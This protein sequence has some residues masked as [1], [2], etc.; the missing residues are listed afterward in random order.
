MSDSLSAMSEVARAKVNLTLRVLGR[1][2]DGYHEL[3]SLVAFADVGDLLS[4]ELADGLSLELT[5]PFGASL[6]GE[7]DNLV[8]RAARALQAA[9]G[10]R[11]GARIR[12]DKRL[13]V[14]SGI[15]GGSA[16]AA[17]TLRGLARLW[18]I[19]D[20]LAPLALPLGADVPVCID[21]QTVLMEGIGERLTPVALPPLHMVLV[22]PG[23]AVPTGRVFQMLAAPLLSAVPAGQRAQNGIW[24]DQ[25]FMDWLSRQANDLEA[26]ARA[27]CP[28]VGEVV[29]ALAGTQG[30]LI[31][32]MSGSGA[33]CFGLY[34]D[35]K[36]SADAADALRT[37]YP[38]WW[39]VAANA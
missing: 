11:D 32:R 6:A 22:N 13:P 14:A 1:R 25:P 27:I 37:A 8:L 29:A 17:A 19:T 30:S 12:L 7:E 38:A 15:G 10:T 4:F 5:G 9:A 18:G 21:S 35:K 16:D 33:T 26:P 23:V 39:V 31:A 34:A 24:S 28:V 36:S 20:D 2:A 3:R